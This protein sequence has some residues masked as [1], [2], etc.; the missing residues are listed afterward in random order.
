MAAIPERFFDQLVAEACQIIGLEDA[1]KVVKDTD[2]T[3]KLCVRT[4]Y[5]QC[6]KF[7]KRAFHKGAR[8][9]YYE[10]YYGPLELRSLPILYSETDPSVPLLTVT[11]NG[12]AAETED[13]VLLSDGRLSLMDSIDD[14]PAPLYSNIVVTST[15]GYEVVEANDTL[16]TGLLLQA[17]A[18]YHRKDSLG[19]RETQGEKGISRSPADSG[20]LIESAKQVLE[21]LVY[22]GQG[23]ALDL[24]D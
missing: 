13:V 15:T 1:N 11:V 23:S 16:Y 19:L 18:N 24:G 14:V 20:E 6:K 2:P 22:H 10:H 17:I 7:C 3:V 12:E 9:D 21:A 4:A 8:R 5:T